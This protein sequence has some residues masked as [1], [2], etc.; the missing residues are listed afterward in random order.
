M[1]FEFYPYQL[2]GEWLTFEQDRSPEEAVNDNWLLEDN[3]FILDD[4]E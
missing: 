3:N 2:S 1:D 4:E